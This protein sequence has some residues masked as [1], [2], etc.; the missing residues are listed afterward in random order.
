MGL[1]IFALCVKIIIYGGFC[2]NHIH[3]VLSTT[4][5]VRYI[6]NR[7]TIGYHKLKV[8]CSNVTQDIFYNH[9]YCKYYRFNISHIYLV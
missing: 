9:I 8:P 7:S 6:Y 4:L 1:L 2:G 3:V 5:M